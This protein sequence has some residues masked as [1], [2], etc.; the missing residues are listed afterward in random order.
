MTQTQNTHKSSVLGAVA[1]AG[2]VGAVVGATAA[3]LADEK[4]R[5]QL[6]NTAMKI[7]KQ[8]KKMVS[9]MAKKSEEIKNDASQKMTQ[10]KDKSQA[11][12]Q[13]NPPK[14]TSK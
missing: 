5:K 4:K 6:T 1:V 10:L 8:G 11:L 2:T 9:D 12:S 13:I 7:Q 3:I 14:K